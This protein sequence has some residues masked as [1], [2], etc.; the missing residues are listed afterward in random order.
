MWL[1]KPKESTYLAV[2]SS[3]T[4]SELEYGKEPK[5]EQR[6]VSP[7]THLVTLFFV[8]ALCLIVGF[9]CG[10]LIQ[11]NGLIA[12]FRATA[13]KFSKCSSPKIRKEWRSL[14][15]M[16]KEDYVTAVQCLTTKQSKLSKV[17]GD[18]LYNDFPYLHTTIGGYCKYKEKDSGVYY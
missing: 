11:D 8:G 12:Q 16:E 7:W 13:T 17:K 9:I 4:G 15:A 2:E 14:S 1:F 10:E 3:E 6:R 18:T 5:A